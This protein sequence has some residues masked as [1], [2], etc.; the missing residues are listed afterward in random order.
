MQNLGRGNGANFSDDAIKY[1]KNC[2]PTECSEMKTDNIFSKIL[3][4]G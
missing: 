2:I 4:G 3:I 1:D